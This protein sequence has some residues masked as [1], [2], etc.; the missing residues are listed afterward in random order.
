VTRPGEIH[1][2]P[3]YRLDRSAPTVA[4]TQKTSFTKAL[5]DCAASDQVCWANGRDGYCRR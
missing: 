5:L 2:P 1:L 3:G 4:R